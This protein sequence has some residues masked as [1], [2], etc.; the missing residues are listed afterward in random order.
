M[1]SDTKRNKKK[2]IE[3]MGFVG[4]LCVAVNTG[5]EEQIKK[6]GRREYRCCIVEGRRC[7]SISMRVQDR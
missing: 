5:T 6:G 3:R 4:R 2:G 1:V 7:D